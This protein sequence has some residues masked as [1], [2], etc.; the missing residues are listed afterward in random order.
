MAIAEILT[1]SDTSLLATKNDLEVALAKQT[2][3]LLTWMTGMLL[4]QTAL[5]VTLLQYLA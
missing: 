2:V 5:V 4:A 3:Q 1:D